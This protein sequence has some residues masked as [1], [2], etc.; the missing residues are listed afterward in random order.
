M[1]MPVP[2]EVLLSIIKLL[3]PRDPKSV[4]LVSSSLK[5]LASEFL[6]ED[7]HISSVKPD[8]EAFESVAQNPL[9]SKHVKRLI[10]DA[11]EFTPGLTKENYISKLWQAQ[12]S[13]RTADPGSQSSPTWNSSDS[14]VN[15]WVNSVVIGNATENEA[16]PE[17][18]HCRHMQIGI[19]EFGRTNYRMEAAKNAS[20]GTLQRNLYWATLEPI[21]SGAR[22][23]GME[24]DFQ[25][26]EVRETL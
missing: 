17:E 3:P 7:L 6:L 14:D 4:K 1:N 25:L 12:R 10:Y 23:L 16:D 18:N 15:D 5:L 21:S 20:E 2:T 24:S 13:E 22:G 11:T 19:P 8:L 26:V 9:L